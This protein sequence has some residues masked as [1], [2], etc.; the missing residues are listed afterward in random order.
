MK[1][2]QN[3]IILAIGIGSLVFLASGADAEWLITNDGSKVEIK[4]PWKIEG[5]LVTFSLP[6]GTLGSL[7]A[8]A[9]D[10]EASEALLA[11]EAAAEQKPVEEPARPK[12]V[13]VITDA[14]VGHPNLARSPETEEGEAPAAANAQE[15]ALRVTGWREDVDLSRP[16]VQ[17]SGTLQNP[18]ENPATSVAVDVLLLDEQ[19]G[20]LER[21][22]AR[23]ERSFLNPGAS[24]RFDAL[25][26]ETLSY[27]R[28]DFDIRSRGFMSNPPAEEPAEEGE[29]E[30]DPET[31]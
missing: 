16:A 12:A 13:M 19:G 26:E 23:L 6:N 17:I 29:E 30:S 2:R 8:S 4:G 20:L 14:D 11:E 27:D 7:P 1:I 31:E 24:V 18:T 10:L 25:F 28:V 22:A 5:K 3:L 21:S 9:V 15:P